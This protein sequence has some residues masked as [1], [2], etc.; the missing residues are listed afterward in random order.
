MVTFSIKMVD[1]GIL[2]IH[3]EIQPAMTET[4]SA[5]RSIILITAFKVSQTYLSFFLQARVFI[6]SITWKISR[7][8]A[9]SWP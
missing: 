1:H 8:E 5:I 9:M 3:P 6:S 7:I 4:T 2:E